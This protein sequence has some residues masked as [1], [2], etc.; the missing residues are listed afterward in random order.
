MKRLVIIIIMSLLLVSCKAND[1]DESVE[2]IE[3][4]EETVIETNDNSTKE[5]IAEI[6]ESLFEESKL[7]RTEYSN[8][9]ASIDYLEDGSYQ[10]RI[11]IEQKDDIIFTTENQNVYADIYVSSDKLENNQI[12]YEKDIDDKSLYKIPLDENKIPA[13]TE[14]LIDSN[15]DLLTEEEHKAIREK[16]SGLV[17]SIQIRDPKGYILE[18]ANIIF[19]E[20]L[21]Q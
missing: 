5:E 16:D 6:K 13:L 12:L 21:E 19:S 2:T 20:Y 1:M 7:N 10:V 9:M 8:A 14:I 18:V 3:N 4:K 15:S 17:M 11:G